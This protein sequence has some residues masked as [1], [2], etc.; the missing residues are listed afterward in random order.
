M[1]NLLPWRARLLQKNTRTIF[2]LFVI[3]ILVTTVTL[4]VIH[5]FLNNRMTRL[6][7]DLR[8]LTVAI[9]KSLQDKKIVYQQW[10]KAKDSLQNNIQQLRQELVLS[11]MRELAEHLPENATLTSLR[12]TNLILQIDGMIYGSSVEAMQR[13]K[14][15]LEV[16]LKRPVQMAFDPGLKTANTL[17]KLQISL[18]SK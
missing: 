16:A 10:Q 18:A 1:L 11:V 9:E 13:F 17:F 4:V 3:S 14:K 12:Y 8:Y 15:E 6:S 7:A 5:C 2:M